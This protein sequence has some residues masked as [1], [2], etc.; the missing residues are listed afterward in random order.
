MGAGKA[1]QAGMGFTGQGGGDFASKY[2]WYVA[3]VQSRVSMNWLQS[4]IDPSIQFAPR[5]VVTFQIMRDGSIANI[6]IERS[7]G[8]SSVD[9]SVV[10]AV[11]GASK[12]QPLPN[13]YSGNFV[14]VEFYFDFKR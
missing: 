2:G 14:N 10:R 7:S 13:E 6:Q 3:A 11:Q 4:S 8:N 9:T 5:T 12:V 1:T